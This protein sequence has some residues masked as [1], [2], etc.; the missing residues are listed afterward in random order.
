VQPGIH[1]H[2][3]GFIKP[4]ASRLPFRQV[5]RQVKAGF[6][7]ITGWNFYGVPELRNGAQKPIKSTNGASNCTFVDNANS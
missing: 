1:V 6:I 4:A 3:T 7:L 2:F 5:R